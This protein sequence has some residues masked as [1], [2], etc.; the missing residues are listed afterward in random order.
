[1][2]RTPRPQNWQ[3]V[4]LAGIIGAL[5]CN[6]PIA[7]A[8][9]SQQDRGSQDTASDSKSISDETDFVSLF[10]GTD[11][12]GWIGATDGYGVED[13]VIFCK[14]QGGNLYTAEEYA[15]FTLRFEFKLQAGSNNGLGIRTPPRGDAAYV[16]MELQILDN[17]AEQYANLKEYQYH[18]SVYGIAPAKRGF[19]KS[20]G[21]WN[22]Q[23]VIC[24]GRR[25]KVILNGETIVDVDLDEV[26]PDGKTVDGRE[27]PGLANTQGHI[28]FLGHGSRV[29]FRNI[30]IRV[31]SADDDGQ[32]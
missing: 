3:F 12:D 17:T 32:Q 19:L 13:G 16:G 8:Q 5:C 15:N 28:G 23:E 10:N 11:L 24:D 31:H 22:A 30:R 29:E 2:K 21:E 27:H 1:M 25:V 7:F 4:L 20:V 14:P 6:G 26:A 9:D 18:G